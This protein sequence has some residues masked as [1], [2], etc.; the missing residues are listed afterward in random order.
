MKLSQELHALKLSRSIPPYSKL[1]SLN[2]FLD[3]KRI[4]RVEERLRHSELE[5][6]QKHPTILPKG[7]KLTKLIVEYKHS[8]HLHAV[9]QNLHSPI[10]LSYWPIDGKT[11]IKRVVKSCMKCFRMKPA[12]TKFIMGE[13]PLAR[14]SPRGPFSKC[15]VYYAGPIMVKEQTLCR[16]KSV[17][18]YVCI[19]CVSQYEPL[20]L[21]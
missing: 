10:R 21:S 15:G 6:Y 8:K 1:I 18:T 3:E 5:D 4:I 17:K 16:S 9:V 19:L 13:L 11:L 14:V 20:I 7:H 2:P 12:T